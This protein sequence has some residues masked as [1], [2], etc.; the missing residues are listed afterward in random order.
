MQKHA[1][2][3][4]WHRHCLHPM[5]TM[6]RCAGAQRRFCVQWSRVV[7]PR[8]PCWSHDPLKLKDH[9]SEQE[10]KPIVIACP[11]VP[12]S[13]GAFA[14]RSQVYASQF[15]YISVLYLC[16]I[17]PPLEQALQVKRTFERTRKDLLMQMDLNENCGRHRSLYDIGTAAPLQVRLCHRTCG[18]PSPRVRWHP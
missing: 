4:R 17:L 13:D 2:E 18:R 14:A 10:R 1:W 3:P 11:S 9:M 12:G 16:A 7:Q 5:Q 15:H 6:R 8:A